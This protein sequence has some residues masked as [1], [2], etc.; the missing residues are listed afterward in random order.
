MEHLEH[1]S[2][3]DLLSTLA[4][5]PAAAVLMA[6]YGGL[7]KLAQET[8]PLKQVEPPPPVRSLQ[9]EADGDAWKG[10]IKPKIRLMGYWLERAGFRPGTR[11][12]VTCV[13]PGVIEL[14]SPDAMTVIETKPPS[15]ERPE[16]PF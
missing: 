6:E 4:G 11:V 12:H 7:T 1:A 15:S 8:D 5:K 2:N 10:L 13:A 14:R 9:I 16:C 3:V